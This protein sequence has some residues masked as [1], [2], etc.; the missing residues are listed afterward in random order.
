MSSLP[1]II[2]RTAAQ[3]ANK[4]ATR[5]NGRSHTWAGFKDRI[6]RLAGALQ[7]LGTGDGDRIAVLALN[8]DRYYEF[9]Y[10]VS[11]AGAAFVPINTRLAPAEFVHW[12]NDSGSKALFVDDTFLPVIGQIRDQ[13]ESVQFYVYMGEGKAPDGY[14]AYEDLVANHEPVAASGRGGDDLAG[15]FYTGGTTGKSKGVMLS[16]RNLATNVLQSLPSFSITTDDVFLHAAP[17][18]HLADGFFCMIAATLGCTNVIV[19]GFDP[20]LVLKT[21]QEEKIRTA[22]LVPTMINILVNHPEVG[23]Y[24]LSRLEKLLYGASPMPEAVILKAME[25]IPH[26]QFFQAYGQTESSPVITVMGPEYH[27]VEGPK[28]GKLSG[29]GLA[30]AGVDLA[31]HDDDGKLLPPGEVGEVCIR[32]ENVM[33]GYWNLPE[34]TEETLRD[35]WLHTGDGGR[36]DEEGMLFIVDRVKDMIVSGGE[37]VYSAETEQAVYAHPAVAECAVIGI[38][39]ESW[40]EQ[41]HAIVVLKPGESVTEQ[42]LI[43]HCKTLVAGYKCPRSVAFRDEPLPL[44]GAGKILKKDLRAPYWEGVDRNVN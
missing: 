34:I 42:E 35:G 43:D 19:P 10:G 12:L 3:H 25:V 39:H 4:T 2:R 26:V 32:G 29:A 7:S 18:F 16:H 15:L 8:S 36:M 17:M 28:A 31:I 40:G 23:N 30:V 6:A 22:L 1:Q 5:C 13:L 20:N 44:S 38:P 11:W 24:D 41:V 14:L 21:L 33:L 9:Y 37:N 27:T